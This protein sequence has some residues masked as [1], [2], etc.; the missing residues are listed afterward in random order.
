M[1]QS[2]DEPQGQ[3]A[4]DPREIAKWARAYGQNRRSV[5]VVIGLLVCMLLFCA[6]AG[7]SYLAGQAYRHGNM[8]LLWLYGALLVL[9]VAATIYIAVPPWG[10]RLVE[11]LI[12]RF[13]AKEGNVELTVPAA[14]R[15]PW[16]ILFAV[17]FVA[18]NLAQGQFG[19]YIPA[20][21]QQPISALYVIPIVVGLTMLM[22]PAVGLFAL[23]WPALYALHAILIVAGAPILFA[24]RW[25]SL[26]Y[27]IPIAGY[28]ILVY[29]MSHAYS[30]FALRRLRSLTKTDDIADHRQ[31]E[32]TGQ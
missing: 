26:N 14:S 18:C 12:K 13:Y 20:K 15:R 4:S 2:T 5:A 29:G 21:Y 28:G 27:L 6:I 24:G 16:A 25:E 3:P 32:V 8:P 9:P 1:H 11:R 10:A 30:R 17:A 22:R 19:D 31:H 7:F 23:V